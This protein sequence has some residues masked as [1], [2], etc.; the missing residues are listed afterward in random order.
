[1]IE[2]KEIKE[3][4]DWHPEGILAQVPFQQAFWYGEMQS[5]REREVRRFEMILEG[6]V[7][8]CVQFVAYPLISGK[9]YWYAA[10]G[11]II[12]NADVHLLKCIEKECRALL[13]APD[14]VFV[15]LDFSPPISLEFL[16]DAKKIFHKA[17]NAS[18]S[19][20]YFQPRSEWYTDISGSAEEILAA[21]HQKTRYSVR[22]AEKK[23]V[24]AEVISGSDLLSHLPAFLDIMKDTAKR[25]GFSLHDDGYYK[26]FFEAV[27]ERGN[28]F[29]VAAMHGED[30]LASHCIAI[31]GAV[32]HYVFGAS[33]DKH[34]ELCA[35]YLA[36][37]MGMLEAKKRGAL[38][39]NFGGI[40]EE[41]AVPHFEGITAFKKKFGGHAFLH[42][43][44][45]DIVVQPFWYYL[46]V[47]R[48]F[49]KSFV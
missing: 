16:S 18:S 8:M 35:P 12:K 41:G 34:K 25:N 27:A 21:M 23:G 46:Y 36:H 39:Y 44:Y 7:R 26:C 2:I 4:H 17:S 10:Y 37:Y 15:R 42:G 22:Y 49:L 48:K 30:L 45:F 38:E 14:V 43:G 40:S 31:E 11:P 19:G 20:S 5:K 28:G 1:M 47:L 9:K 24:K 13:A 33:S 29:I 32:A 6:E 3:E